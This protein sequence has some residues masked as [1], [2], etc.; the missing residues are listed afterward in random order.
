M[1]DCPHENLWY[2][3]GPTIY[4]VRCDLFYLDPPED[5]KTIRNVPHYSPE[6][7]AHTEQWE[8]GDKR[9]CLNCGENLSTKEVKR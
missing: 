6:D 2:E 4:C 5:V 1:N 3:P 8:R 7:C 9:I